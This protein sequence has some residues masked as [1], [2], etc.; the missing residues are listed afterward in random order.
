MARGRVQVVEFESAVLKG[1]PLGDPHVRRIP[2]W[3]PPSYDAEPARRY[4]VLYVLTGFTGRGRMLLNDN[5]WSPSLD[6]RL[7]ALVASGRCGEMIVVMPD[8]STR[9]GGSQYVDSAATGRYGEHL[10][11]E[12]V[13]W[14]DAHFRTRGAREAR[15][16][17][18]K[19]SGGFGALTLGMSHPDVFAAVACH[20]GDMYFEFCYAPDFPKALSVLQEAGGPRAFLGKFEAKPQKG[21]DDFLA[22]NIL[23]MAACYSPDPDAELGVA[24]PFDLVTAGGRPEV[25]ARWLAHDPLRRLADRAEALRSLKLLYLD[26]G[27]KDEFH[28]HHGARRFVREL[29]RLGIAHRHEE[30]DDGH[31]NVTYRYDTSLPLLAEA[32]GA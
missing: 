3:T 32:L 13:P 11:A 9:F 7:D 19:S 23:A 22:L 30:Y 4:P 20:S 10:V 21:K 29:E 5:L 2:V 28:L 27:T 6:D 15:G 24:L 31:M 12:L 25:W 8:C 18:G 14:V 1:N 17:A 26:C 16:V